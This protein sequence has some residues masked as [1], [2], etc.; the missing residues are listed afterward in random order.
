MENQESRWGVLFATIKWYWGNP[1]GS[2]SVGRDISVPP[3]LCLVLF[4]NRL[5]FSSWIFAQE[6]PFPF[7]LNCYLSSNTKRKIKLHEDVL[8]NRLP[9][10]LL[11][12][13][14]EMSMTTSRWTGILSRGE[15]YAILPVTLCYRHWDEL[16]Q[17]GAT[18]LECSLPSIPIILLC[19]LDKKDKLITKWSKNQ[20]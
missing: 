4:A 11:G 10:A 2:Q 1:T 20:E 16:R 17:N 12:N 8:E 6:R 18:W 5:T 13:P 15:Q 14:G 7:F 9:L 19:C 3:K